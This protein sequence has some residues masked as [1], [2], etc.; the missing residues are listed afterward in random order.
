MLGV[1]KRQVKMK[2]VVARLLSFVTWEKKERLLFN[3]PFA[4]LTG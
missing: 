2:I 3:G 4:F 1:L